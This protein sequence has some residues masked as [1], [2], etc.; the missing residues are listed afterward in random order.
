M[1]NGTTVS[2]MVAT[3]SIT[4]PVPIVIVRF[5][6]VST[7]AYYSPSITD[8]DTIANSMSWTADPDVSAWS[9][10]AGSPTNERPL[11]VTTVGTARSIPSER[12][13]SSEIPTI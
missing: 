1:D 3:R 4:G 10:R 7:R 2:V 8:L 6:T 12:D 11:I 13:L 9:A 5:G